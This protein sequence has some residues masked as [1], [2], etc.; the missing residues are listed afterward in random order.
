MSHFDITRRFTTFATRAFVEAAFAGSNCC[1]AGA[2]AF[3]A[4][5]T[6]TATATATATRPT[7]GALAAIALGTLLLSITHRRCG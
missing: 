1:S 7:S 3:A 4:T 5:I 6:T 2:V